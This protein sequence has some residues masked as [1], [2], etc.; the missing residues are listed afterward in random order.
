MLGKFDYMAFQHAN[1][2]LGPLFVVTYIALVYV[3]LLNM[4]LAIINDAYHKVKRDLENNHSSF[5]V[6]DLWRCWFR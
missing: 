3:I 2:V 6:C 5:K 1:R 4:F